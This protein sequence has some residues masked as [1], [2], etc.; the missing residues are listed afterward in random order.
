VDAAATLF[1]PPDPVTPH[2]ATGVRYET[3][4]GAPVLPLLTPHWR[5]AVIDQA[6]VVVI[7]AGSF[8]SSTAYHLAKL[9]MRNVVLLD[10]FEPGSQT[11]PRAC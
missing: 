3:A 7:G 11:S 4:V 2:D 9:G 5:P 6:D 1:V 10:R 8:G